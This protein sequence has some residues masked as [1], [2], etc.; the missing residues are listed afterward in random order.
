MSVYHAVT[1]R[2]LF[3]I[4]LDHSCQG[5][6]RGV[7]KLKEAS[8]AEGQVV[9]SFVVLVLLSLGLWSDGRAGSVDRGY[10]LSSFTSSYAKWENCYNEGLSESLCSCSVMHLNIYFILL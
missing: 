8:R 4:Y 10:S 6:P 1:D 3:K 5:F 9:R 2:L 7:K